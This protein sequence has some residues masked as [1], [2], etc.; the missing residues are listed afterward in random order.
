MRASPAKARV[1]FRP[2]YAGWLRLE[3]YLDAILRATTKKRSSTFFWG[4]G[5]HPRQN[6]GYAYAQVGE[7]LR[8]SWHLRRR[9]IRACHDG[10]TK[11][12]N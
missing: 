6:P 3:V 1:N 2:V 4:G 5:V 11:H 12:I 10:C 7:P 8:S 9:P